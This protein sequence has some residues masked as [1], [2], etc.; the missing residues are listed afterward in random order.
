MAVLGRHGVFQGRDYRGV[1]VLSAVLPIPDSEWFIVAKQDTAEIFA[2]WHLRGRLILGL[3]LAMAGGLTS[4]GLVVGERYK[5]AHYQTLYTSEAKLRASAERHSI[6]LRAIGDAVI[7]TDAQGRVELINPVA[8][9]LVGWTD[10]EAR[11]MPLQDVFHIICEETRENVADPVARVLQEG[12]IVGLANH[13]LLVSRDGAERPI[14][15]SAAPIRDEVGN[16]IGVVLVFRDQT[17]ERDYQTLFREMLDGF[18]LHEIILDGAGRPADYRFLAVNPAFERMTGLK[19]RDIVGK[20][21]LEVLPG[22]ESHWI[23]TYGR[24]VL[25]GESARFESHSGELGKYFDVTAFR[26]APNQFATIFVDIT[27]RKR[28]EEAL[29]ASDAK[30]RSIL[31]NIGIGVALISPKMEILELNRRMREWFPAVDPSERDI[32]FRTFNDPPR[33]AICEYC[34]TRKTL[35]DGLVHESETET[36][37]AHGVRNYRVVSS[38]IRDASGEGGGG[39]RDGRGHHRGPHPGISASVSRRRW[40]RWAFWRAVSP[41]ITT[42]CSA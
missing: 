7:A 21:V 13:T 8:E 39:D 20:T 27:E 29:A 40:R 25:T 16:I 22:T 38:P 42:T 23:A 2:A 6:T 19:G 32:C 36:P 11:G 12:T 15:D 1:E 26:S 4:V 3:I 35:Q 41:T 9:A 24:V 28:T 37:Q 14:A 30:I 10:A 17:V 31:D 18:A 33:E 5:K 34:P